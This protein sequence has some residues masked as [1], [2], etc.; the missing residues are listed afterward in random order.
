MKFT[1]TSNATTPS[2]A[3]TDP[4][5]RYEYPTWHL[6][7]D[8]TFGGGSMS[9][10]FSPDPP[11]VADGVS[12]WHSPT[13]ISGITTVSDVVFTARFRKIRFVLAGATSP[14]LTVEIV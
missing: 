11:M 6:Y 8:G 5:S 14:N 1:F 13:A 9:V 2:F 3:I 12:R 10:Q 4:G 7:T